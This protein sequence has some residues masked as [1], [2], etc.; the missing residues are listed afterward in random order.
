MNFDITAYIFKLV[1]R[2]KSMKI[3][4]VQNEQ[5]WIFLIRI[6]F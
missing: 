2:I 5:Y 6:D 1:A 3:Y 4:D